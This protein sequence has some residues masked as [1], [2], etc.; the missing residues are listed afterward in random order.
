MKAAVPKR[1]CSRFVLVCSLSVLANITALAADPSNS[2]SK[3]LDG[4]KF[5][6]ETGEQRK[7]D[8]HADTITFK[9]GIFRSLDCE[10][11]GFGSAPY[12]VEQQGETYLFT[13]TL[14]SPDLGTLEWKGTIIGDTANGTFRWTHK[15]WYGTIKRDYWFKGTRPSSQQ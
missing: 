5:V 3:A 6:G 12:S 1:L 2:M 4:A 9:D 11:W 10:N 13:S 8:H 15:R 7:G 14:V